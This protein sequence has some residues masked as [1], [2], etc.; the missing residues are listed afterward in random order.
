MRWR[1]RRGQRNQLVDEAKQRGHGPPEGNRTSRICRRLFRCQFAGHCSV[2]VG[3]IDVT[4]PA[5]LLT[6][7]EAPF[8]TSLGCMVRN[9]E[10]SSRGNDRRVLKWIVQ[11][12]AF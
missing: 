10:C 9:E 6:A 3:R 4:A 2:R 11:V 8:W 5:K 1:G 7:R 12:N